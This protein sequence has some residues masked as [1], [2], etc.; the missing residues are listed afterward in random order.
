MF[1]ESVGQWYRAGDRDIAASSVAGIL[2]TI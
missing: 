1:Q 2:R